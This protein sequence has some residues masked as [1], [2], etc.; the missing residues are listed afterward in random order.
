M[1]RVNKKI[2]MNLVFSVFFLFEGFAFSQSISFETIDK[3]EISYFNY[4]DSEFLGSFMVIRDPKTWS[5]FWDLHTRGINPPPSLPP[6]DFMSEM[7][8]VAILGYQTSGG[9]PSIEVKAIEG[10]QNPLRTY[11]T[12]L[13]PRIT[14][15]IKV[16][17]EENRE[18][19]S[20]TV[21]TNPYHIVKVKNFI[22]V[23]F[24]R[25]Q[26]KGFCKENMDCGKNEYCKKRAGDCEGTGFC[27]ARPEACIQLFLPVCGCDGLTYGNECEAAAAGISVHHLGRCENK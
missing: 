6:I 15:G 19:G 17:V 26:A 12:R 5:W 22:S 11:H 23:V 27:R 25:F 14:L 21:I 9:G 24:E 13:G 8:L 18:T 2:L 20:L 4:G 7:V 1:I 16:Y 10:I 3:G